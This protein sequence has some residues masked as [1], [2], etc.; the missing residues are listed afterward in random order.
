MTTLMVPASFALDL[1]FDIHVKTPGLCL[2]YDGRACPYKSKNGI[3]TKSNGPCPRELKGV[4]PTCKGQK[5][6]F[7][8]TPSPPNLRTDQPVQVEVK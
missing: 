6:P 4:V 2:Y 8:Q 7:T 5:D 1:P 3:K